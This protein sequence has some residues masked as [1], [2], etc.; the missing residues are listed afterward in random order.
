[1]NQFEKEAVK[2]NLDIHNSHTFIKSEDK[3]QILRPKKI[4]KDVYKT[5]QTHSEE[6]SII[7]ELICSNIG[8]KYPNQVRNV[9]LLHD[10]GHPP[11]GHDG[12][13]ILDQKM[14]ELGLKE[15]FKDNNAN[16]DV[17]FN[18]NIKVSSY[19]LV[20]IIKRKDELYDY[21][22]KIFF[23]FLK[24]A[25]KMEKKE[26][27]KKE[28]TMGSMIMDISDEI[29]YSF[30][31]FVDGYSLGYNTD[32]IIQFVEKM[33][34]IAKNKKIKNILKKISKS[35]LLNNS[36]RELRILSLELKNEFIQSVYYD[37]KLSKLSMKDNNYFLL[38]K[39]TKFNEDYFIHKPELKSRRKKD[40]DVFK[41]FCDYIFK[42][43]TFPSKMYKKIHFNLKNKNKEELRNFRNM[44]G[45]STDNFVINF[46]KEVNK[47]KEDVS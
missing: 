7:S 18:N 26:W 25:I 24:E 9:C 10:I 2:R 45:D 27:G 8:F 29:A 28:K 47:Y 14:I 1:M 6:V 36:K 42:N 34:K 23:P 11:F 46:M 17:I 4:E 32:N 43:R 12:A 33:I 22:K 44:I 35:L 38:E 40:T 39:F 15:G 20:S 19:E 5:R 30:S 41:E 3:T 16:F 31:D 13:D 21:Q 37:Y